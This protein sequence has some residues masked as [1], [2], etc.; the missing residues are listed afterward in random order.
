MSCRGEVVG[1]AESPVGGVPDR[2]PVMVER[3]ECGGTRVAAARFKR[4]M[5]LRMLW[6]VAGNAG[7]KTITFFYACCLF[8]HLWD[9]CMVVYFL[10]VTSHRSK[11]I[12]TPS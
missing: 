2:F 8:F 4:A 6:L 9:L 1:L 10:T 11:T 7:A 5:D 3:V 12:N